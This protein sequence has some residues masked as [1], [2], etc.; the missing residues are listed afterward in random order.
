MVKIRKKML[1][2]SLINSIKDPGVFKKILGQCSAFRDRGFEVDY[3]YCDGSFIYK[4]SEIIAS[5]KINSFSNLLLRFIFPDIFT[6]IM[7]EYDYDLIYIRKSYI[8]ISFFSF[9][10]RVKK[11]NGNIK[12]LLEIPTFP[13]VKEL[14][15]FLRSCLYY[16]E[17]LSAKLIRSKVDL[18]TFYG[19]WSGPIWNCRTIRLDNAIDIH[20][21]PMI[22]RPLISDN[23]FNLIFVG[24]IEPRH[25][26]ERIIDGVCKCK[27]DGFDNYIIHIIGDGEELN[28][29][30]IK[31]SKAGVSDKFIFHGMLDDNDLNR[32]FD[33]SDVAIGALGM[34]KLKINNSSNIKNREYAARGLPM[35]IG[36]DDSGISDASFVLKFPNDPSPININKIIEWVHKNNFDSSDIRNYALRNLTWRRQINK[37]LRAIDV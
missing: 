1:Y 12:I 13:Y 36:H 7:N 28:N 8:S 24:N 18:I 32:V 2:I 23:I 4:N 29:L 14:R 10:S 19:D 26:L 35:I 37:I 22:R 3:T 21:I 9:L 11:K 17:V 25:G 34:Y 6:K 33:L 20:S 30:K 16:Y 15:G 27:H 5:Y 31:V